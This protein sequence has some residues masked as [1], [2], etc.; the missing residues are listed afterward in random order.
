MKSW[1]F[2]PWLASTVLCHIGPECR[3]LYSQNCWPSTSDFSALE[4]QVSQPLI[5]PVPS[6]SSCYP[7]SHPSGNCTDV[8]INGNSGVW[9][10]DRP[11][12]VDLANFESFIFKNG[13][14]S[15]C[16]LNTSLAPCEQGNVPIIGVDAR[17]VGDVQ[18]AIK[19]VAAHN[20]R[21]VI[22]N[23]G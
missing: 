12:S 20:L 1:I 13:S 3:C 5:H 10:A 22:K 4:S 17:S 7:V 15:A 19:F 8:Q 11:G 21:L 9:R 16:Y 6:A 23:T 18:A 2:L 14:I